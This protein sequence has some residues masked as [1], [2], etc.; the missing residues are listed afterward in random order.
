MS[1]RTLSVSK[2]HHWWSQF[3][4]SSIQYLTLIVT[5]I[6]ITLLWTVRISLRTKLEIAAVFCLTLFTMICA[7]IKV[8]VTLDSPREDDSWLFSWTAI[9]CAVGMLFAQLSFPSLTQKCRVFTNIEVSIVA[10]RSLSHALSHIAHP[11]TKNRRGRGTRGAQAHILYV[12]FP[13]ISPRR[14]SVVTWLLRGEASRAHQLSRMKIRRPCQM[15]SGYNKFTLW[16]ERVC[17]TRRT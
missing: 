12:T 7:V 13:I 5:I 14:I 3:L 6:P 17:E 9:E 11:S 8:I 1:P 2:I 16:M 15:R 10:K 4:H